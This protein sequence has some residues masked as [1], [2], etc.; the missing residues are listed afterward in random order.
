MLCKIEYRKPTINVDTN[1][2]YSTKIIR[3]VQSR[4]TNLDLPSIIF[5]LLEQH[6][7]CFVL[8]LHYNA[9]PRT[10]TCGVLVSECVNGEHI[11][12]VIIAITA[13]RAA[14]L[15]DVISS[16][17]HPLT[18]YSIVCFIKFSVNSV[19]YGCCAHLCTSIVEEG[20]KKSL[21]LFE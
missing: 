11:K 6:H 21:S 3:V 20:Y 15:D 10:R 5:K 2:I 7:D 18:V 13:S 14:T 8:I 19:M 9:F 16:L 17:K 1:W 4:A 12:R